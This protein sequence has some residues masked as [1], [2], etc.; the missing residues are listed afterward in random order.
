MNTEQYMSALAKASEIR[1][2]RY[3]VKRSVARGETTISEALED[4]C[5]QTMP[6][7]DLLITQR[8]WGRNRTV[9]VLAGLVISEQRRV[10]DLTDRQR[11]LLVQAC[12]PRAVAA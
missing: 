6:V 12:E 1:A 8:G 7:F 10:G 2:A 5:C 9:N 3:A 11:S 4:P